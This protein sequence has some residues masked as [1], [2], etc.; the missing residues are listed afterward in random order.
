MGPPT[1]IVATGTPNNKPV[2]RANVHNVH[3]QQT[4]NNRVVLSRAS[5]FAEPKPG[6][7]PHEAWLNPHEVVVVRDGC[8]MV[9]RWI[10]QPYFV[11]DH[12]S[13]VIG[14]YM[15]CPLYKRIPMMEWMTLKNLSYCCLCQ[16][17]PIVYPL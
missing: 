12:Q 5:L 10:L 15:R 17:I 1:F 9:K 14:I 8:A 2:L 6:G 16:D 13:T 3:H 4:L 7:L 11:D